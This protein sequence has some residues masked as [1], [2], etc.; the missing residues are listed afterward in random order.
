MAVIDCHHHVWQVGRRAHHWPPQARAVLGRDYTAADLAVEMRQ[1]GVDGTVLMQSLN[2]VGETEEFLDLAAQTP[3]IRGVVGWVALHDPGGVD[4]ALA[5]MRARGPLKGIRH[6]MRVESQPGF[7]LRESVQRSLEIIAHNGLVFET[8][9]TGPE[10]FEQ[11]LAVAQRL[12]NMPYVI[13]HLGRPPIPEKGWE[14]WASLIRRA[15]A[16]PNMTIKLSAGIALIQH[17]KWS[18]QEIRPYVEH[19]IACFGTDRVMAG[20]NWPV[21]LI[22]GSYQEIWSGIASLLS[23]HSPH[24]QHRML[25]SNAER[26]YGLVPAS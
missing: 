13:N 12:P 6:L 24:E 25:G 9:P 11:A 16:L 20:S 17:W 14:P 18:T 1:A 3:W 4:A 8:V 15:A 5:R 23:A 7:L 22:A 26:I 10:Q 21:A 2:E 19:V